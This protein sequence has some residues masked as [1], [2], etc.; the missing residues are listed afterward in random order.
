M[1]LLGL[2]WIHSRELK[3]N[4]LKQ[5]VRGFMLKYIQVNKA[6]SHEVREESWFYN[7]D[8]CLQDAKN[9]QNKMA[10]KGCDLPEIWVNT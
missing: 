8:P 10:N 3:G 6:K 4:W 2:Q 5:K 7:L 9:A 1:A